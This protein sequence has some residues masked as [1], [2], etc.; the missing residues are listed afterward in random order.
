MREALRVPIANEQSRLIELFRQHPALTLGELWLRCFV[1]GGMSTAEQLEAFVSGFARFSPHE[2]NV[3][4]V[5]MNEYFAEF[6]PGESV[7]YIET[8]YSKN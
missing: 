6:D 7:P 2:H 4:A 5:A 3:T 8:D 1:L